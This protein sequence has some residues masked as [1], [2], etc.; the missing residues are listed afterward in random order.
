MKTW[1]IALLSTVAVVAAATAA[2]LLGSSLAQAEGVLAGVTMTVHKSPTCGC[3][4]SYID[5]LREH[6]VEV[7]VVDTSDTA[8]AKISRG[9]PSFAWSCHTTEVEGYTVEGHVP[10]EAV[11]R[12]LSERPEIDGIALPGMPAGSPGM[13]GAKSAPFEVVAFDGPDTRLFGHF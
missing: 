13:N 5:I 2:L 9:V 11:E 10:I 12:L 8:A 7:T 6:G 1:S 4:G 3:C